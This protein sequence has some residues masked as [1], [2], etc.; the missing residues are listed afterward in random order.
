MDMHRI[1]SLNRPENSGG[2]DPQQSDA[3]QRNETVGT[4]SCHNGVTQIT[5]QIT[6]VNVTNIVS[7]VLS[8]MR[9]DSYPNFPLMS[10][11]TAIVNAIDEE[12]VRVVES[13]GARE[14]IRESPNGA[15]SL[16]N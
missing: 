4:F 13:Q 8:Y 2:G 14:T 3:V 12:L 9:L 11:V 7:R 1:N 10:R 16:E 15:V 5:F 6:S